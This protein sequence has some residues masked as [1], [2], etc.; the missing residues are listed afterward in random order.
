MV[1]DSSFLHVI[2]S[3]SLFLSKTKE[4]EGWRR[5]RKWS[6]QGRRAQRGEE[7][8]DG[9]GGCWCTFQKTGR[10]VDSHLS[11]SLSLSLSLFSLFLSL[12]PPPPVNATAYMHHHEISFV[13]LFKLACERT[14]KG[15]NEERINERCNER[16]K[17]K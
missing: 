11:S 6:A 14:E 1:I 13:A 16:K 5:K 3:V 8:T 12:P 15:R 4:R 9:E 2:S 17:K 10:H 7:K